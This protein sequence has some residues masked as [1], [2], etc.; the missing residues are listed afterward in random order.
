MIHLS[1]QV[2][3]PKNIVQEWSTVVTIRKPVLSNDV[4][5]TLK[6]KQKKDG[7]KVLKNVTKKIIS[8]IYNTELFSKLNVIWLGFISSLSCKSL[9]QTLET[10]NSF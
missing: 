4:Q 9:T 5:L 8:I 6:A 7:K 3:F 10:T 2:A 1:L